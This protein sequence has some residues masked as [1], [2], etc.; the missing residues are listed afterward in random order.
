MP[1]SPT[2]SSLHR[3]F[4]DAFNQGKLAVV[5]DVLA[6]NHFSHTTTSGNN[7]DPQSFKGL[8]AMYRTGFPDLHCT[9]N[10]ELRE[11]DKQ[12]AHWTMSG[13]H[14][15]FFLGNAPTGKQI[16][17]HGSILVRMEMGKIM[18]YWMLIDQFDILQ[19][20]GIIPR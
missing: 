19:Q 8:I 1:S 7:N 13:T 3:I 9:I 20:L 2:H 4:E 12:A 17:T 18:E 14:K 15:G 16:Q 11:G 5:D 10:N 6:P